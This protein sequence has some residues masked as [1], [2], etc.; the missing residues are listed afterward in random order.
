MDVWSAFVVK[1]SK[2]VPCFLNK[3]RPQDVRVLQD[4]SQVPREDPRHRPKSAKVPD[5]GHRQEEI[6]DSCR[7]HG[8]SVHVDHQEEDTAACGESHLFICRQ[9]TPT[10]KVIG[11][12]LV[13]QGWV[14][15]DNNIILGLYGP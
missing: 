13:W 3:S 12:H 10:I 2:V 15:N 11:S 6:P 1:S 14:D 4:P 9:S 7:H 5:P 8:G